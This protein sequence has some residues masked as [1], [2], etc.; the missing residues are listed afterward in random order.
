[1]ILAAGLTPAWQQILSFRRFIPGEV[2]RAEQSIWC[3]SGKV[4]NVGCALHHLGASE[5]VIAQDNLIPLLAV[6]WNS[7]KLHLHNPVVDGAGV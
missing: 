6:E 5:F 4:L 2:N 3:G 7:Q 1:M